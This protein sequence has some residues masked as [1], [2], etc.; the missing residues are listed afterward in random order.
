MRLAQISDVSVMTSRHQSYISRYLPPRSLGVLPTQISLSDQPVLLATFPL[1]SFLCLHLLL[2]TLPA[3]IRSID[4]ISTFKRHLKFHLFPS[5][6][7]PSSHPV[8][9]PQIRSHEFWRYINLYVY[10]ICNIPIKDDT[11]AEN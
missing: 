10:C 3:H 2:G 11:V 9:A 7:L 8:P 6:P 1:G 5:L 4:T